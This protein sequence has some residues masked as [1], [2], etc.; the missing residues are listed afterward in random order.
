MSPPPPPPPLVK[1]R[2]FCLLITQTIRHDG[3]FS[4]QPMTAF[5]LIRGNEGEQPP[6]A[7]HSPTQPP[8]TQSPSLTVSQRRS[9]D[10][11]PSLEMNSRGVDA[12]TR[13]IS[14][15]RLA[16]EQ[17][18]ATSCMEGG[19]GGVGEWGFCSGGTLGSLPQSKP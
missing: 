2:N 17:S 11:L 18:G 8:R 7:P 9:V 4:R 5:R 15:S 1:I 13:R 12:Q 16:N 6:H 10:L 14:C 19:S 3:T